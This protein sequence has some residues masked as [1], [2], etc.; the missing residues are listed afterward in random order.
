[1]THSTEAIA[2]LAAIAGVFGALVLVNKRRERANG[3]SSGHVVME[4]FLLMALV[5][6]I[7][8]TDTNH[9]LFSMPLVLLIVHHLMPPA[10]PKWAVIA[11]VLVLLL[12]GGNWAD[13]LGDLS[14]QMV[15]FSA[16]IRRLG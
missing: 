6:S 8:L 4:Y 3:G 7:T 14:D 15:H 9:F 13:A 10:V 1:M 12:F 11:M 5:P 16:S 2:V